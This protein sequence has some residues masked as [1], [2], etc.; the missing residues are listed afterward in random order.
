LVTL[1]LSVLVV[2]CVLNVVTNYKLCRITCN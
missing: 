1:Y 2:T